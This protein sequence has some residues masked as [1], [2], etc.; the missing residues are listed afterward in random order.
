MKRR[1]LS[2]SSLGSAGSAKGKQ[3]ASLCQGAG[4]APPVSADK[5]NM[6]FSPVPDGWWR[7]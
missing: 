5:I 1:V 7:P 3:V 6:N 4:S 2:P